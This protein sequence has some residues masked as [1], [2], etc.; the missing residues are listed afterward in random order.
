MIAHPADLRVEFLHASG[1]LFSRDDHIP[2][3]QVNVIGQ[4]HRHTLRGIGHSCDGLAH[5]IS[6]NAGFHSARKCNDFVPY[7]ENSRSNAPGIAAEIPRVIQ[8]RSDHVLNR[9]SAILQVAVAAHVH[10]F[11]VLEQGTSLVPGHVRRGVDHVVT[12]QR[13]DGNE[14]DVRHVEA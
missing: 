7:F 3:R 12:Q 9:E 14:L 13:A 4:C 2:T 10:F 1:W 5:K 6:L 8:L 11:E